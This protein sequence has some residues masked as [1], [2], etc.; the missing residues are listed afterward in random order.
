M[1]ATSWIF[2]RLTQNEFKAITDQ[3]QS[4]GGGSQTYIDLPKG[5]I[6]DAELISFFGEGTPMDKG[7]KWEVPIYSLSLDIQPQEITISQ[8]R[9]SSNCIREQNKEKRVNIWKSEYSDF[10]NDSY[11]ESDNPIYIFILKSDEDKFYAGWFYANDYKENWFLTKNLCKPLFGE[12]CGYAQFETPIAI[13]FHNFHWPFLSLYCVP[14]ILPKKYHNKSRQVIYFGAPG[15]G[16]SH[17]V[18]KILKTEAPKRNIR[19]TFHPD[20]DYSSFVGCFKPTMRNGNIEYAFTAQAFINAYVEAWCDI[21]HPFYLVI[22]EIN[23]GNCAQIFG[24]IFQLLDRNQTGE[25]SYAIKPD[26]DLQSYIADKLSLIPNIPEEIRSGKEMRLPSNLFIYATMNTSDQSLFPID[27]A[28]KRRWDWKYTAIKLADSE[29]IIVVGNSRFSWT[30]FI[31]NVNTKIYNLTRSEDKQLGYWFIKPDEHNNIDWE[32]FVSKA[33]FYI[34]NDIVKDYASMENEDSPFGKKFSF[35][36]FF[37]E[38][39][40]PIKEQ[41]IAF[42][43]AL[44]VDQVDNIPNKDLN[45]SDNDGSNGNGSRYSYILNG[46]VVKGIGQVVRSVIDKLCESMDY[47]VLLHDFD[48][49]VKKTHANGSGMQLGTA[50]D[51]GP[52]A[53]GRMRWWK[54]PFTSKDGKVFSIVS[55][56]PDSYYPTIKKFVEN[57]PTIFPDGLTQKESKQ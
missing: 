4:D 24:D 51:L 38:D 39:G 22:E 36:T 3:I 27:S 26:T 32:L 43:E 21:S 29:H 18:D 56:W 1:N 42:L 7:Y 11:N 46:K 47:D 37:D 15:T 55:L 53:N 20:S 25:S 17:A 13:D 33:L 16:K 34:W 14:S 52:D 31:R 5:K 45:S 23:R 44:K 30:S 28:F 49:I 57:Y 12:S 48:T 8:R 10:P 9:D 35:T 2:R 50:S 19:T 54:D 41:V 6:S 40:N